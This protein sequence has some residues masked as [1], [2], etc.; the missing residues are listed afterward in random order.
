MGITTSL[1]GAV[2]ASGLTPCGNNYQSTRRC[3]SEWTHPLCLE[4]LG[5][6][7]GQVVDS[8]LV[9]AAGDGD[10]DVLTLQ[11]IHLLEP[12]ARDQL[13]HWTHT[14][15]EVTGYTHRVRGHWTHRHI[16]GQASLDTYGSEI[17]DQ[18]S[19]NTC[20]L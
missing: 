17:R 5:L 4:D 10:E 14:G 12:P 15:S 20:N 1:Q 16:Q 2:P 13:V 19:Q 9:L 7:P 11:H 6:E 18:R 8:H 3:S